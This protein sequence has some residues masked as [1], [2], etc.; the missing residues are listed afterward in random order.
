MNPW[1]DSLQGIIRLL[2]HCVAFGFFTVSGFT[3]EHHL[4]NKKNWWLI[5]NGLTFFLLDFFILSIG[6]QFPHMTYGF[7]PIFEALGAVGI[8]LCA[9][10]FLRKLPTALLF[11]TMLLLYIGGF[12]INQQF[13]GTQVS[14]SVILNFLFFPA[15]TRYYLTLYPISCWVSVYILGMLASRAVRDER[16]QRYTDYI[17]NNLIRCSTFLFICFLT[18]RFLIT[19]KF[20]PTSLFQLQLYPPSFSYLFLSASWLGFVIS[21]CRFL[22]RFQ[23]VAN[24]LNFCGQHARAVYSIHPFIF[25]AINYFLVLKPGPGNFTIA[26]TFWISFVLLLY[27]YAN[28]K[29]KKSIS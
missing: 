24:L 4:K 6:W 15:Q 12:L 20:D 19:Q 10:A 26:F 13:G 27:F 16:M 28:H 1:P 17:K 18:F 29:A 3:T 7:Y 22:V 2:I 5:K 8:S 25:G 14:N 9:G 23:G 21:L 11:L